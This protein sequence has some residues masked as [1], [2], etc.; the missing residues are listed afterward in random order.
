MPEMAT[1]LGKPFDE[2]MVHHHLR[3]KLP[4]GKM[5]E[6]LKQAVYDCPFGASLLLLLEAR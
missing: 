4:E 1:F 2:W 3:E 5:P 6:P